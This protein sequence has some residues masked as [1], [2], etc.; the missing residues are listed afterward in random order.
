MGRPWRRTRSKLP[1]EAAPLRSRGHRHG[2]RSQRRRTFRVRASRCC[3]RASSDRRR[4]CACERSALRRLSP[5]PVEAAA[6]HATGRPFVP[7]HSRCACATTADASGW[8]APMKEGV[9]RQPHVDGLRIDHRGCVPGIIVAVERT[10]A[11]PRTRM[12]PRAEIAEANP[13]P[14]TAP[15]APC[16]VAA[17]QST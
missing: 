11:Q 7:S 17:P 14:T 10:R 2:H 15:W 1:R 8:D 13:R 5:V 6:R 12:C 16:F 3:R 4:G 9:S